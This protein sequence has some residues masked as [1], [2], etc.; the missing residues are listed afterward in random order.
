MNY[1]AVVSSAMMALLISGCTSNDKQGANE[2]LGLNRNNQ[3]NYDTPMRV[4]DTRQNDNDLNDNINDNGTNDLRVSEDIS[5]RV[6]AL[7]EV[8]NAW[9]IV[10]DHH[11]YVGA[12]LND[13]ADKDLTNELKDRIADSVRGADSSV[14]KVYVSTN[15][16]FVQRMNDYVTDINNGKPV[17]GFVDEFRDLVTRIFPSSE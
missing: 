11:A 10:T 14:E 5:N 12:E 4:S 16:D 7:K 17:K 9:V 1:K 8:K 3:D 13:G 2:N 15:P 6:E